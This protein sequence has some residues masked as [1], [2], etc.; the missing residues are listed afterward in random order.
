MAMTRRKRKPESEIEVND[1][2]G[3][4][5]GTGKGATLYATML[6][7]LDAAERRIA[8]DQEKRD[9]TDDPPKKAERD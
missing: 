4:V 3:T 2:L 6:R 1:Q 5:H 7:C 8:A 9:A